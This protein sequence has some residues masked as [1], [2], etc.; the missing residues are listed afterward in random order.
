MMLVHVV[1]HIHDQASGPAYSVPRLCESLAALGNHVELSCLAARGAICGV[2][3]DVHPQWPIGG[4]FAISTALARTLWIKA[5][6]ADIVHN[7]S[8]WSMV[9]IAAGWVVPGRRAKL[10]TSPRGTLSPWA[11][12]RSRKLKGLLWPLQ[13]RALT[14]ADMLHAT[15]EVEY[16]Q[17][18]ALGLLS[19]VMVI[20]NGVDL[21]VLPGFKQASAVRTL[22]FLSRIH[23]VKGLDRLLRI[24]QEL[25]D[26]HDDWRLL[27]VGRGEAVHEHELKELA[28]N[29]CLRRVVFAGPLYGDDKSKAFLEADLFV[30]PS[31]SENFGMVVAEALAHGCPALVSEGA[32]WAD[33][34]TEGCGWWVKDNVYDLK[35]AMAAAMSLPAAELARMGGRGRAWMERDYGWESVARRMNSAYHWLLGTGHCPECVRLR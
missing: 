32:P 26:V 13:R 30:L 24:W 1:P 19:P 16:Q 12:A 10:V 20:P 11:L 8:L 18:R 6:D 7:H 28:G 21:P 5:G 4:R 14:K 17:I 34:G 35:A 23:P 25:Q 15:S 3:I 22:L 2:R 9:N 27:I 33:L 29:L 31:H